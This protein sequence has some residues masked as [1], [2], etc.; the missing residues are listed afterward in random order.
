LRPPKP[1][2]AKPRLTWKWNQRKAVW[3]PYHRV[4][5]IEAGKKRQRAI[6]LKWDGDPKKLD[7][8][9]WEC[10][11]GGHAKQKTAP[12]RY[13]WEALVVLWRTDTRVQSSLKAGTKVSYRRD[14]DFFLQ[15]N[16]NKDVRKTT[17]SG[18]RAIHEALSGTP[19]KA[20][21]IIGTI[22]MLWNYGADKR[23]WPLGP[24]PAANIDMFGK[25]REFLP[26]PEW[27]VDKLKDAPSEVRTAAELILGT[28]QRPSA[29][30]KMRHDA[31][32][33]EFM[34]VMDEK[35]NE[36]F[37][38]YCPERLRAFVSD[39]PKQGAFLLA[40]NLTEP[41]GYDAVEKRFRTWRNN[42]GD[43]AK[44][45]TL[46]GLRKLAIIHMAEAGCT[47]A[48]IQAITNQSM[49]MVAYYRRLASRKTLSKNAAERNKNKT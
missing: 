8:L 13:T 40:K 45:F 47:D 41:V 1:R 16:A 12:S 21:K 20:D 48:E 43:K 31:F 33:G 5:W 27:L 26:W 37:E 49:E 7:E 6:L 30:I 23:D 2:I 42:L 17:R 28:G 3:E 10:E 14:M 29:A 39:L 38:I 9:F 15:K 22:K 32:Q 18:V 44:P 24:N 11:R 19:R 25:Q 34:Q 36:P 46:H 35:R 4:S